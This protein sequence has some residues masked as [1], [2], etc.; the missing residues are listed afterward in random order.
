MLGF[1]LAFISLQSS[2]FYTRDITPKRVM[3]GDAHLGSLVPRQTVPRRRR[4]GGEPLAT[5]PWQVFTIYKL[6]LF[7]KCHPPY[8]LVQTN[9]RRIPEIFF[10]FLVTSVGFHHPEL[11]GTKT[12]YL[13][14]SEFFSESSI[15]NV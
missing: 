4:C 2:L 3:S 13:Y 15:V 7:L 9:L 10:E 11:F 12:D 5:V 8:L 6:K 1:C 14:L